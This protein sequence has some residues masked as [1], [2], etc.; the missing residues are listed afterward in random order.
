M[1]KKGFSEK[2]VETPGTQGKMS[3]RRSDEEASRNILNTTSDQ[4]PEGEKKTG[5]GK[6]RGV[7]NVENGK[8]ESQRRTVESVKTPPRPV[9]IK[10]EM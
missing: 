5:K 7:A 4:L 9:R 8:P 2:E 10:A 1:G 6:A 3:K